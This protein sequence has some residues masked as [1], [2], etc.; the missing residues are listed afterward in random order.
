MMGREKWGFE[1]GGL[2]SLH[3]YWL[4]LCFLDKLL[5]LSETQLLLCK[6]GLVKL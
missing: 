5:D 1:G 6:V 3:G 2:K 4:T